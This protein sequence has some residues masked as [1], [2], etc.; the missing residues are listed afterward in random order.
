MARWC[1]SRLCRA[2]H[3]EHGE[4]L[5]GPIPVTAWRGRLVLIGDKREL[6]KLGRMSTESKDDVEGMRKWGSHV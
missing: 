2:M 3:D 4:R 1:V 5:V 6:A